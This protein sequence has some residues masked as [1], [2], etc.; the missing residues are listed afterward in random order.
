MNDMA[1]NGV[2]HR[3]GG[4]GGKYSMHQAP[5]QNRGPMCV[6]FRGFGTPKDEF[7]LLLHDVNC[8]SFYMELFSPF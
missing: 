5:P 6:L 4:V 3:S 1:G 2:F 8:Y 7:Q